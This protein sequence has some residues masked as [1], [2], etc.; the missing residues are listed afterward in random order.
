MH[1][2]TI[3]KK[4]STRAFMIIFLVIIALFETYHFNEH[5]KLT[6][7]LNTLITDLIYIVRISSL[8]MLQKKCSQ[9]LKLLT[10]QL[11]TIIIPNCIL[12][13]SISYLYVIIK[14]LGTNFTW[15]LVA[16]KSCIQS[17]FGFNQVLFVNYQ[18]I[19]VLQLVSVFLR[20]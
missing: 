15:R 7:P 2:T 17:V 8:V 1:M 13:W 18:L 16:K 3:L 19:L 4:W 10:V 9:W 5:K 6:T 11:M 12:N 14:M 20:N